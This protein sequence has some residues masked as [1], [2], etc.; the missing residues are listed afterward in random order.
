VGWG[1][2]KGRQVEEEKY[3]KQACIVEGNVKP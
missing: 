2:R 1:R 3:D